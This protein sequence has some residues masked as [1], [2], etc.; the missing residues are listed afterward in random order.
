MPTRYQQLR[1]AI[2]NLAAPADEQ[3][4]YLDSIFA[5]LT[6]GSAENYGNDELGLEFG[7][8]YAAAE[9]MLDFGEI[10]PAEIEAARPLDELIRRWSGRRNADFWAREAL[11]TDPR[12]EEVRHCARRVLAAFSD[13]ERPSEWSARHSGL[14][15]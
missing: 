14:K 6:L 1:Q 9:H 12:W 15:Q 5:S 7:E 3:V 8:A 13:E 10:R 2:A 11:F 4:T